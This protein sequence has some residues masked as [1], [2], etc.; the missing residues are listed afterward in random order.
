MTP[1]AL[2]VEGSLEPLRRVRGVPFGGSDRAEP[3]A[4]TA[5]SVGTYAEAD[6]TQYLPEA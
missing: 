5:V 4:T 2:V 3:P 6:D 1:S